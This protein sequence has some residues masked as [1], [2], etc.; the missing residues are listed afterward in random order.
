MGGG[1]CDVS[2]AHDNLVEKLPRA[3]DVPQE[4]ALERGEVRLRLDVFSWH[5]SILGNI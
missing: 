4:V 5:T 2:E 1:S 3:F